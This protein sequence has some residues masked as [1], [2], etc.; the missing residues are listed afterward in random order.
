MCGHRK[1]RNEKC[2]ILMVFVLLSTIEVWHW[3]AAKQSSVAKKTLVKTTEKKRF[4][5]HVITNI[6]KIQGKSF[7]DSPELTFNEFPNELFTAAIQVA[8]FKKHSFVER[9]TWRKS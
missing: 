8:V 6:T 3:M 4:S 7:T 5:V 1:E 2:K 9:F